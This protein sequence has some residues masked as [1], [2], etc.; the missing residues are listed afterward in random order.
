M[1]INYAVQAE[2][3]DIR[4]D[5]PRATDS[6][7]V[8]TNVWFWLA[9]TRASSAATQ[10]APYQLANYPTYLRNAL[11]AKAKL[12]R[13]GISLA[14][15]SHQIERAEREIYELTNPS[16][17]PSG[18][19]SATGWLRPKEFRHNLA[20]QRAAVV[21]EVQAAWGVIRGMAGALAIAVNEQTTEAALARLASQPLDGYDLFILEAMNASGIVQI[22]T[23]D[24]DYCTVPGVR[25]FTANRNVLVAASAQGKLAS[26][27]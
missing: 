27:T 8:D 3:I 15:L 11:S 4:S 16:L 5:T 20:P 10:P 14:E 17:K 24:G 19:R 26:R 2:V 22:L 9:Y 7:L 25:M 1:P 21:A 18:L 12:L 6:F 13:S 23:D